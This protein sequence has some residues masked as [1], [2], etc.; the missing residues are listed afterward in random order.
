[1]TSESIL[2]VGAGGHARACI[3][4]IE[5]QGRFQIGGIIGLTHEVGGRV[6]DYPV[7]GSED[8]LHS[9][10]GAHP[11]ALV[12]VGQIKTP[13]V[14]I[15]LFDLLT[16]LSFVLPAI[17][18]PHAVVS[19]HASVAGGSI[20]MHGAV[21]NAC[22]SVG[23]NCIINTN[24]LVEHD[25]RIEDH[26]HVATAA[27][28]NSGVYIHQGTFIGSNSVIRQGLSIGERCLIGMGQRVLKDCQAGIQ[29]PASRSPYEN[30]DHR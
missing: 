26:C 12:A 28:I 1:V 19:R 25:V 11:N 16:K 29:L 3:D 15:R 17:V 27:V 5:Q 22:A 9:L 4:V 7:L 21:V 30:T 23:R 6:L 2:L 13:D 20:V 14:R 18:S 8:D 24:A 10:V